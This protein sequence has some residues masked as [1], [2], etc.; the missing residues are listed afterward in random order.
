ME[1]GKLGDIGFLMLSR[2]LQV[3]KVPV[4]RFVLEL[5]TSGAFGEAEQ[6]LAIVE[7]RISNEQARR[8]KA[9]LVRERRTEREAQDADIVA[10][11]WIEVQVAIR[12]LLPNDPTIFLAP[13]LEGVRLYYRAWK[14]AVRGAVNR[15]PTLDVQMAFDRI[16]LVGLQRLVPAAVRR[17][18]EVIF[19]RL[20][21]ARP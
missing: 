5:A 12:P 9:K 13:Y 3:C 4:G 7:D 14:Q 16:E 21:R 17:M 20:Q 19:D 15:D 18:R 11:L 6:G 8:A 10:R 2:Y 1:S